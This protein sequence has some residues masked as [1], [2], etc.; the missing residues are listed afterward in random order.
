[1]ATDFEQR[2]YDALALLEAD[3]VTFVNRTQDVVEIV[4]DGVPRTFAAECKLN[5]PRY[6]ADMFCRQ[7]VSKLDIRSG[8][9][10]ESYFGIEGDAGFPC[11][12]LSYTQKERASIVKYDLPVGT[13]G[14]SL[15]GGVPVKIGVM[16]EHGEMVK[17]KTPSERE[18]ESMRMELDR[19]H[20]KDAERDE[21]IKSL[22]AQVEMALRPA[23]L[24]I[25]EA[26]GVA[27]GEA[28]PLLPKKVGTD[29]K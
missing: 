20:R 15:V 21:V 29:K 28:S 4:C 23:S 18:Q 3:R 25:A 5:L 24:P 1:M 11:T 6:R 19:M 13:I 2:Q 14:Y 26:G 22:M 7:A 12:P 10:S 16:G 8:V 27:T 9:I 17:D